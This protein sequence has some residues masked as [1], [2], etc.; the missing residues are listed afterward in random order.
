M[1]RF[2]IPAILS[3]VFGDVRF[4]KNLSLAML[5][6]LFIKLRRLLV[7][8]LNFVLMCIYY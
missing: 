4:T 6:S 7:A 3:C 5:A 2:I 8:K 1:I